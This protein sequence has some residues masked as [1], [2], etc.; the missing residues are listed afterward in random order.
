M[1]VTFHSIFVKHLY[2]HCTISLA[3]ITN[4]ILLKSFLLLG[5]TGL[6][7]TA[8]HNPE[9]DNGVKLIDTMG[10]MM[11]ISWESHAT[12]LANVRWCKLSL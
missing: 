2:M 12:Q 9:E 3:L 7:V 11:P 10:E 4:T 5:M 6:M 1:N 8:S